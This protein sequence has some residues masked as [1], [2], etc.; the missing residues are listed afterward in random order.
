[1]AKN[2]LDFILEMKRSKKKLVLRDRP[3]RKCKHL[4]MTRQHRPAFIM[5]QRAIEDHGFPPTPLAIAAGVRTQR[6]ALMLNG[7]I[8]IRLVDALKLERASGGHIRAHLF[9]TEKQQA[10]DWWQLHRSEYEGKSPTPHRRRP[11]QLLFRTTALT[12]RQRRLEPHLLRLLE[13]RRSPER[14]RYRPQRLLITPE[15][16]P[17]LGRKRGRPI[18]TGFDLQADLDSWLAKTYATLPK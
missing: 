11:Q 6:F 7:D 4:N 16:I 18:R 3:C 15:M 2:P 9:V 13:K 17:F 10:V 1:M 8:P 12:R 5:L 14:K